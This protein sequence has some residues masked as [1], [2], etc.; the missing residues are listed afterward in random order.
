[1]RGN[2]SFLCLSLC[3]E[4]R[5]NCP[6][7]NT[8]SSR[9]SSV[10]LTDILATVNTPSSQ[11]DSSTSPQLV[12]SVSFFFRNFEAHIEKDVRETKSYRGLDEGGERE[13]G[14]G[15][16]DRRKETRLLGSSTNKKY[17]I[18]ILPFFIL[19]YFQI[20]RSFKDSNQGSH[21]LF[22]QFLLIFTFYTT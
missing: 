14:G 21:I 22:T 10:H 1:M 17:N 8:P 15:E 2:G 11:Y 9:N 5:L 7:P 19:K 6:L 20:Y 4:H 16:R 13:E 18:L 12:C 3:S